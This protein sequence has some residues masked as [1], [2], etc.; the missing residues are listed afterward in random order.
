MERTRKQPQAF[1]VC[2]LCSGIAA[3]EQQAVA[4]SHG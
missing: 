1:G 2:M 3:A 4:D